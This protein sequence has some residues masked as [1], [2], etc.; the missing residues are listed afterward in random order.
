MTCAVDSFV[1]GW[2]NATLKVPELFETLVASTQFI[3]NSRTPFE[4]IN[5][6]VRFTFPDPFESRCT[7]NPNCTHYLRAILNRWLPGGEGID[8]VGQQTSILRYV[9]NFGTQEDS[10]Y[11]IKFKRPIL[12]PCPVDGHTHKHIISSEEKLYNLPMIDLLIEDCR[13]EISISDAL[14]NFIGR[15]LNVPRIHQCNN[16]DRSNGGTHKDS[17][18]NMVTRGNLEIEVLPKII[19]INLPKIFVFSRNYSV[20]RT[21]TLHKRNYKLA[22]ILQHSPGH[23]RCILFD[24][25]DNPYVYDDMVDRG[26]FKRIQLIS[27]DQNKDSDWKHTVLIYYSI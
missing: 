22:S 3:G 4:A 19:F 13:N 15:L 12:I 20:D 23:F 10:P 6:Y 1:V 17:C 16:V 11:S 7:F 14:K 2:T 9:L 25:S 8:I 5:R 26:I 27:L 18:Y 21:F 24:S